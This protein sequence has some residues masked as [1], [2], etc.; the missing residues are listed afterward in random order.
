MVTAERFG[1]SGY[2]NLRCQGKSYTK[3]AY[4][5][6]YSYSM[7]PKMLVP[8]NQGFSYKN[9]HF[10]VF[11]GVPPIKE[12]PNIGIYKLAKTTYIFGL[13]IYPPTQES[14]GKSSFTFWDFPIKP[15][16]SFFRDEV[17][18][19]SWVGGVNPRK[20]AS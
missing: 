19:V 3:M 9:H 11:W 13:W 20:T 5:K 6:I 12:T 14:S 10:G 17:S 18:E 2:L 7:F 15:T 4:R 8:N 16:S 1:G